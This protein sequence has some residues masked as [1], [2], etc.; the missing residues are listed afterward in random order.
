MSDN[1]QKVRNPQGR[2]IEV[3]GRAYKDWIKKGFVRHNDRL[4]PFERF[5]LDNELPQLDLREELRESRRNLE[6]NRMA[7]QEANRHRIEG[8][9][10]I[11]TFFDSFQ[12]SKTRIQ[13]NQPQA[14]LHRIFAV[15][16][17]YL[18][19]VNENNLLNLR[20]KRVMIRL[21]YD[22]YM[23]ISSGEIVIGNLQENLEI[24]EQRIQDI[25]MR[26]ERY[27]EETRAKVLYIEVFINNEAGGC[28]RAKNLMIYGL[29]T[30]KKLY[31]PMVKNNNCFFSCLLGGIDHLSQ[32]AE[33]EKKCEELR[34]QHFESNGK[35]NG[36]KPNVQITEED[37]SKYFPNVRIYKVD[38]QGKKFVGCQKGNNEGAKANYNSP[39]THINIL[40]HGGHYYLI[41]DKTLLEYSGCPKCYKWFKDIDNHKANCEVC[42]I[43]RKQYN[44]N[45]KEHTEEECKK[46]QRVAVKKAGFITKGKKSEE[47]YC[48]DFVI[49]A[50]FETSAFGGVEHCVYAVGYTVIEKGETIESGIFDGQTS[51]K[52]FVDVLEKYQ[53]RRGLVNFYNGSGFDYYFVISEM[54][55]RDIIP[56]NHIY[57]YGQHKKFS[58]G[59]LQCFDLFLHTQTNLRSAC[60]DFGLS[61]GK[62]DFDHKLMKT[63][64]DVEKYRTEWYKYLELD[65][66]C[67]AEL[68]KVYCREIYEKFQINVCDF[69]TASSMA[70]GIWRCYL[71]N[72]IKLPSFQQDQFIRRSI[73]GGRVYP[74]KQKFVSK[75]TF[76]KTGEYFK[77]ILLNRDKV[78][79]YNKKAQAMT[80]EERAEVIAGITDYLLD[81]DVVSLYPTSMLGKFP[82]G[83]P[84]WE[85]NEKSLEFV[86]KLINSQNYKS[87]AFIECDVK[88]PKNLI[89]AVLPRREEKTNALKWDLSDLTKQVYNTTDLQRAVKLGYEVIKVHSALIYPEKDNVFEK[90]VRDA[91][92][93]K[94]NSKKGTAMYSIAKLLMNALYGKTLQ[95]PITEDFTI[96]NNIDDLNK[97]RNRTEITDYYIQERK[98]R[99]PLLFVQSKISADDEK[100]LDRTITKPSHLGSYVLGNSRAIMDSFMFPIGSYHSLENSHFRGDTD[101]LII[102]CSRLHT[103][104]ERIG[105]NLG[106][107]DFD[108]DGKII[109]FIEICPK[110]YICSYICN[111]SAE[112]KFHIK[113]KGFL[114]D[115][116]KKLDF[117]DF[118]AMLVDGEE[119][120]CKPED[121][122]LKKIGFKLNSKQL[123][124]ELMACSIIQQDFERTLNKTKWVGRQSVIGDTELSSIY[125]GACEEYATLPL[126]FEK[127]SNCS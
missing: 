18:E 76:G 23:K 27:E 8:V 104:T 75:C 4:I 98:G 119:R 10:V 66:K 26:Q 45:K 87:F 48:E 107:L 7:F 35:Y 103:V 61:V 94:K 34:K 70:M 39:I 29:N 113:A 12:L 33:H 85:N 63:W 59:K 62:G 124:E 95:R 96:C 64:D 125:K 99:E 42:K 17:Q 71:E 6:R 11:R 72:D 58:F 117:V 25:M 38:L 88:V 15:I 82:V 52:K 123:A 110:A 37:V 16:R 24:V 50:D 44:P 54:L 43:C 81:I 13:L 106:D 53:D 91:F 1:A 90:Y 120:V 41:T 109:G 30:E 49:H 73:Y 69:L 118:Y 79:E 92:E 80:T 46:L 56:K 3:G 60:K 19:N 51:L 74:V 93:L 105:K 21:M 77:D 86:R 122:K 40:L 114:G 68:Y 121:Q 112:I 101:S 111:K 83:E 78:K 22:N 65:V 108:I 20:G 28:F 14:N 57:S 32:L 2:L 31:S 67:L 5:V 47:Y 89:N 100:A 84:K 126:F 55:N 127:E 102:H 36:F 97:I 9:Q 116:A 115:E